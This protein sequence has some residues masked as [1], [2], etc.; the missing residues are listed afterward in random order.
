MDPASW[1]EVDRISAGSVLLLRLAVLSAGRSAHGASSVARR[2]QEQEEVRRP[3]VAARPVLSAPERAG[4]AAATKRSRDA[5]KD[6]RPSA[7]KARKPP[8]RAAPAGRAGSPDRREAPDAR[9]VLVVGDFM[10]SGLAEGLTRAFAQ[11][12]DIRIVDRTNGSS[13]FVRDDF[14]DWPDRIKTLIESREAG[15]DRRHARRQRP[16]ADAESATCARQPRPRTGPRNTQ[17]AHRSARQGD[18]RPQGAVPVG[19]PAGVQVAE[20]VLRTCSPSTTSTARRPRRRGRANSSTS[21][22]ASST[23]TAPSSSNGPDMNGQPVRLRADDG[24][25]LSKAGKRK[26]AFYAEKPLYKLLGETAPPGTPAALRSRRSA[27]APCAGRMSPSTAP[28]PMLAQRP[29]LDGGSELLGAAAP[30]PKRDAGP[31]ARSLPSRASHRCAPGRADDFPG[32]QEALRPAA[33]PTTSPRRDQRAGVA[34]RMQRTS[35]TTAPIR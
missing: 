3:L 18:R 35:A 14:Y 11:N 13:G 27:E 17:R 34:E 29:G 16:P 6:A 24:I 28:S 30:A 26:V 31:P 21:G 10:A 5:I 33:T 9:T 15:R 22:T 1:V 7:P 20:D 19:R 2:P 8:R 32:R 12:P 25:N 23:R 4:R